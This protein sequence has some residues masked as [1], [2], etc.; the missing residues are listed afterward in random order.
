MD[1]FNF[2]TSLVAKTVVL[3]WLVTKF[4]HDLVLDACPVG[5]SASPC[6][7]RKVRF[8]V[9]RPLV[10]ALTPS[11]LFGSRVDTDG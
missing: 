10:V 8:T 1:K 2:G 5:H 6:H 3:A 11:A 9:W 4:N 7:R